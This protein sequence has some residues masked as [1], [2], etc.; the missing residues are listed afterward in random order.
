[1]DTQIE[2]DPLLLGCIWTFK[3]EVQY[4]V[5]KT[6]DNTMGISKCTCLFVIYR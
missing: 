5:I 4:S 3:Y 6:S 1:M 2:K